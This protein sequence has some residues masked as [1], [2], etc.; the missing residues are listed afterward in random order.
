MAV[1]GTW[2]DPLPKLDLEKN[3]IGDGYPLCTDLPAR[4]F[5]RVGGTY[6]L[7]GSADRAEMQHEHH[8]QNY[9]T[10]KRFELDPSSNLFQKLCNFDK[11]SQSCNFLPL[12][13]LDENL[14]C[15]DNECEVDNLNVVIVSGD[16]KYEYVRPACIELAFHNTAKL[17]KVVDRFQNAMCL[18]KDI[19]D[20]GMP[21]CCFAYSPDQTQ[22]HGNAEY[23]CDFSYERTSYD[24]MQS[25]CESRATPGHLLAP[26]TCDWTY[27]RYWD[28][29]FHPQEGCQDYFEKATW[30]WTSATC[31]IMVKGKSW[32]GAT[33]GIFGLI[34]C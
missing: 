32:R 16:I 14:E 6:R 5:L 19:D 21:S 4:H 22:L 17:R 3:F 9:D 13:E 8:T 25:R 31:S 23:T 24:T 33:I 18:H 12:V 2:R 11:S 30:H 10:I 15:Y 7:L 1:E 20:V 26:D 29:V 34:L 27:I 28:N